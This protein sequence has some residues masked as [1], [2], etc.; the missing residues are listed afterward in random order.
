LLSQVVSN[1]LGNALQ[2]GRPE[3]GLRVCVDGSAS[4]RV[5]LQIHNAGVIDAA[6]V[7]QIFDAFREG[8]S[9]HARSKGLGL[10]L[11][12][13]K[14]L[15]EVHGGSVGVVSAAERT[16]FTVDLP[17]QPPQRCGPVQA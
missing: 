8:A 4:G 10:G 6:L 1:L 2:H 11:F 7:P 16:T 9:R 15:V 14:H 12:I 5:L 17:R 13:T 3:D